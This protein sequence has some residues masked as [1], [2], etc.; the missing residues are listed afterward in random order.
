MRTIEKF[1]RLFEEIA[2]QNNYRRMFAIATLLALFSL[3]MIQTTASPRGQQPVSFSLRALS[4]STVTAEGLRGK[5]VV[6]AFGATWLPLSKTQLQGIKQI[7]DGYAQRGVV[8]YWVSTDSENPKSKNF[9]SD[10]Q[11]RAFAVKYGIE[12]T[13]LRDPDNSLTKSL[14]VSQ[15]PSVVILDRK[16]GLFE[17]PLVG[18]DP[19]RNLADKVIPVLDRA[20]KAGQG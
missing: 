14:G 10:D 11:I 5:T 7:A 8:V 15:L 3:Q 1:G 19:N 16:G 13:V 17:A 4:G 6:L 2:V 12:V 20:L 18:L 9:A